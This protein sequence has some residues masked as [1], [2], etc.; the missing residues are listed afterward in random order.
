[1][2]K[3]EAKPYWQKGVFCIKLTKQETE[4]DRDYPELALGI[5]PGSKREGY[6]V[7][8][9][10]QVVLNITT[11][12]PDWVKEKVETRRALRRSR[13]S[14]KTPYRKCRSNR[15]VKNRIPPSVKARWD[16][17]LRMIKFLMRLMPMI[18]MINI[19]DISAT[20]KAGKRRWNRSFSPLEVGKKYCYETIRKVY[21]QVDLILSKGYNTA[22]RRK[23]RKFSK[24][25]EKLDYTWEAH[26]VDSHVLCEIAF[27]TDSKI[28]PYKGFYQI[29]FMQYSRRQL[30]VQNFA[31]GG[32][33][34]PYGGTV[35]LGISRGSIARYNGKLVYIGG[36]SK[37]KLS[38][39]SISDKKR[40]SQNIDKKDVNVLYNSKWRTQ[41]ITE[42]KQRRAPPR[43]KGRGFR[44]KANR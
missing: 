28:P 38:I 34:K 3:G 9:N 22:S 6:T 2:A 39:H 23:A 40:L 25:K 32:E 15:S 29:E 7:T 37:G 21:P 4:K 42:K 8:S 30:H 13:R 14:R 33:R 1:M 44:P 27:G 31:K 19:E 11:N 5:D 43:P 35:S 18:T 24:S 16:A 17:K 10:N 36:T 26:N 20:T 41:F 12:T